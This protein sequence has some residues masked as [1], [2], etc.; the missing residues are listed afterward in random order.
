MHGHI[1]GEFLRECI[2][3]TLPLASS[4]NRVGVANGQ[5]DLS[6]QSSGFGQASPFLS[7]L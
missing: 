6:K 4:L 2:P 7:P 5:G 1:V 3:L